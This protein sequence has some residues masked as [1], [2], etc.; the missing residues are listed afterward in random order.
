MPPKIDPNVKIPDAVKKLAAAADAAFHASQGTTPAP[1]EGDAPP[2]EPPADAPPALVT[3]EVTPPTPPPT[4]APPAAPIDWEHRF[5]SMKGRFE[6]SQANIRAMS[7]QIADMQ[8]R[9]AAAP[10]PQPIETPPELQAASLLTPEE[11]ESFGAEFL[12]VVGK[13]AREQLSPEM[14]QL[15]KDLADL[16]KRLEGDTAAKAANAR[17]AMNTAL[18]EGIPNWR[19]VNVA[20]EFHSWLALPDSFS[21]VIRHQLLSA[22]YEQNNTPRVAAIFNGFLAQEAALAP[23]PDAEPALPGDTGK[24]PLASLAAPGRAKTAAAPGAPVEKPTFTAT[25]VSQFFADCAAGKY[26]GRDAEKAR[27]DELIVVAGREGRIR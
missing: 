15:K 16:Q 9:L 2:I 5:N 23:A 24:I 1:A 19:E 7:D 20:P 12:D 22:A 13:K 26:K 11:R 6:A 14:A 21:G 3:P 4:D 25:D 8:A 17:N 10:T 18:D 27:I